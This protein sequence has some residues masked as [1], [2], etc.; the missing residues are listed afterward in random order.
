MIKALLNHQFLE[1]NR[2]PMFDRYVLSKTLLLFYRMFSSSILLFIGAFLCLII[3]EN[4]QV[5]LIEV[6]LRDYLVYILMFDFIFKLFIKEN[7]YENLQPYLL[8]PIKRKKI[9][10]VVLLKELFQFNS[11]YLAIS[12]FSIVLIYI[13]SNYGIIIAVN[14]FISI[15]MAL[16]INSYAI[17][18]L[19]IYLRLRKIKL[20]LLIFYFALFFFCLLNNSIFEINFHYSLINYPYIFICILLGM[21]YIF[22]FY[23]KKYLEKLIYFDQYSKQDVL[24]NLF[25]KFNYT[26]LYHDTILF[27]KLH[28]IQH[29]RSKRLRNQL[30]ICFYFLIISTYSLITNVLPQYSFFSHLFFLYLFIG[31]YGYIYTQYLFVVDSSYFDGLITKPIIIFKFLQSKYII[32]VFISFVLF[33]F[34]LFFHY[35]SNISCFLIVSVF[36]YIIGPVYFLLFQNA[37]YASVRFNLFEST[38]NNWYSI[39]FGQQLFSVFCCSLSVVIPTYI[40]LYFS[41][42]TACYYMLIS[43]VLFLLTNTLWIRWMSFRFLKNKYS[44]LNSF[45]I[46]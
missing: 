3:E 27:I 22:W 36:L 45:R 46:N 19:K 21:I 15:Y 42:E 24:S 16:V 37:V 12:F 34:S 10:N 18:L 43:G 29:W 33:L 7:K 28:F 30:M 20:V 26:S 35:F 13:N 40:S 1:L 5:Q 6:I 44:K 25:V 14:Y 9:F 4:E 11:I 17:M 2:H 41:E 39:S 38:S 31:S 32:F 8:L 23:L